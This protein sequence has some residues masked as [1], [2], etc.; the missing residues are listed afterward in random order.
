M[1]WLLAESLVILRAQI[2]EMYPGRRKNSDGT[3]GDAAHAR[4]ESDHNPAGG[5]V[6]ALDL[7]HD[8]SHGF[9]I[10]WLFNKLA[11]SRDGRIKYVIANRKIVSAVNRPWKVRDY[12]GSDPHTGH[13]HVSVKLAKGRDAHRW[14]LGQSVL[15]AP[16]GVGGIP[17]YGGRVLRVTRPLMRGTD[18][19]IWQS[20]MRDR[21]WKIEV[22]GV[23]GPKTADV[24]K[25]FQR[26][27][28]LVVDGMVGPVTWR[29][30]WT[31]TITR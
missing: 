28:G 6:C 1:S 2:D 31:A 10:Q 3:I 18:V 14:D 21:G 26:E 20:R 29:E 12:T 7:T 23:Y 19:R 24:A 30:S 13:I 25:K 4:T 22:D 27:K 17:L 11:A 16:V 9:D 15:P 5:I 8:P